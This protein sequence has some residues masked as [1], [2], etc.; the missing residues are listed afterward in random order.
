MRRETR[1]LAGLGAVAL[2]GIFALGYLAD[3]YK[4]RA[5][6][7]VVREGGSSRA[8]YLVASFLAVGGGPAPHGED[9]EKA[10]ISRDDYARVREAAVTW[11]SAG[12]V[13][14][15][16]LADALAARAGEVRAVLAR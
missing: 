4:K 8:A 14:D 11:A 16:A 9:L 2:A 6:A 13:D 3:Q 10:G 1:L 15:A 5:Q 7:P 12:R